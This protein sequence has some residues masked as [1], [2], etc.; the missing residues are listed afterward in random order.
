MEEW[1]EF[2]VTTENNMDESKRYKR[3]NEIHK[4]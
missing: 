3:K 2:I 4:G 1:A